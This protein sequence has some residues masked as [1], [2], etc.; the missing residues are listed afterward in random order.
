MGNSYDGEEEGI[1]AMK[2]I[3]EVARRYINHHLGNS[4]TSVNACLALGDIKGSREAVDHIVDDLE[5]AGFF[6]VMK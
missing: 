3:P 6:R 2:D 4:L 5:K 1:E